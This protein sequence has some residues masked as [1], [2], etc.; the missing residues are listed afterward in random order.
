MNKIITILLLL[1][2]IACTREK[3]YNVRQ[4]DTLEYSGEMRRPTTPHGGRNILFYDFDGG[5]VSGTSWMNGGTINYGGSGLSQADITEV[6]SRANECFDTL[7]VIITTNEA[8]YNHARPTNRQKIIVTSTLWYGAS[9]GVAYIGSFGRGDPCW[10]FPPNLNNE[11]AKV[12]QAC[13]HE[14]GHT[15][16]LYHQAVYD[17][18]CFKI[19][20]YRPGVIMGLPYYNSNPWWTVGQSSLGCSYIQNDLETMG[21]FVGFK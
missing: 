19:T 14:L 16:G 6:I 1:T 17:S 12:K 2:L 3:D 21:V 18:A 7:N 4:C 9:G 13:V 10:V 11:V 5:V 8:T 15:L 20:D